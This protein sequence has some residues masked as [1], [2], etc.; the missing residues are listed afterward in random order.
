MATTYTLESAW[1]ALGDCD[2]ALVELEANCCVP[3]RSPS[4]AALATTLAKARIG[5]A[6]IENGD[7]DQA[8]ETT[9]ATLEDAGAQIGLLQVGCCAPS[10]LPLYHTMLDGLTTTQRSI[11]RLV[12]A[13]H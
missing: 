8:V 3:R 10:R 7:H 11:K 5:L 1:T 12:K 4:M 6:D 9:I 13:P 2:T